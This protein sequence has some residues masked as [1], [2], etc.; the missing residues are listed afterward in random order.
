MEAQCKSRNKHTPLIEGL[1]KSP[2]DQGKFTAKRVLNLKCNIT[3]EIRKSQKCELVKDNTTKDD[4]VSK[5][6]PRK[7]AL[8]D[9]NRLNH[10]YL[11]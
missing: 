10:V 7:I 6:I 3:F 8:L 9:L 4:Q 11:D 1:R 2:N 5:Q